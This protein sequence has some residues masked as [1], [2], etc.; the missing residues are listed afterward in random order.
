MKQN[1][2]LNSLLSLLTFFAV[3]FFSADE[4]VAQSV[5]TP[6]IRFRNDSAQQV[7]KYLTVYYTV[8]RRTSFATS[9]DQVKIEYVRLQFT[10]KIGTTELVFPT[11]NI[12]KAG[13]L[14]AYN[15]LVFVVHEQ[16]T[17]PS[18]DQLNY[19]NEGFEM[20]SL[21]NNEIKQL[22][23]ENQKL[24]MLEISMFE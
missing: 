10:K 22:L 3:Q 23:E 12:P 16:S 19:T 21:I 18:I 4:A 7:G 1:L 20:F 14:A 8:G 17:P 6:E 11:M 5:S 2:L 9:S 13:F 24:L 15:L